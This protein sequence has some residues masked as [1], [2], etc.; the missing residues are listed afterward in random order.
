MPTSMKNGRQSDGLVGSASL[1]AGQTEWLY[2]CFTDFLVN[3]YLQCVKDKR[4]PLFIF[5]SKKG[6]WLY[7]LILLHIRKKP[8]DRRSKCEKMWI[9]GKVE[10]RSDRYFTKCTSRDESIELLRERTVFIVDD[11]VNTGGQLRDFYRTLPLKDSGS[12]IVLVAFARLEGFEPAAGLEGECVEWRWPDELEPLSPSALGML[13]M[14]ETEE[15]HKAGVPFVIDLPFLKQKD[16]SREQI[17]GFFSCRLEREQFCALTSKGGSLWEFVDGSYTIGMEN[18]RLGFFYC[19][20]DPFVD[21][22]RCL[23]QN[24]VMECRYVYGEGEDRSVYVTLTPFAVMRSIQRDELLDR[25]RVTFA[26]T[27]YA[28]EVLDYG[29]K[30]PSAK[31]MNLS[32]ALYRSLVFFFSRYI[33]INFSAYMSEVCNVGL[34]LDGDLI[35]DHWPSSFLNSLP[36]IF[37]SNF[38]DR[39]N[40]LYGNNDATPYSPPPAWGPVRRSDSMYFNIFSYFAY[41]RMASAEKKFFTIEEIESNLAASEGCCADDPDF[42]N[43]FTQALLYLLN[44]SVISNQIGYDE[45]NGVVLRGFRPAE[46]STFLLP[47]DQKAVFQAIYTYYKR[48][49][50][51]EDAAGRGGPAHGFYYRNYAS[52]KTQ[53]LSYIS[54]AGL[55]D[56]VDIAEAEDTL[57]YFAGIEDAV[58]AQQIENKQYIILE[59]ERGSS[60]DARAARLLEDFVKRMEF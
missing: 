31:D 12:K 53:L 19:R 22:F 18:A 30:C 48:C 2:N 58:L 59:L 45:A 34:E 14:W 25:F 49:E 33:S 8:A 40:F 43:R 7:R 32:T 9:A 3:L 39:L 10:V 28:R 21:K 6:Y 15:F 54:R 52:F 11:F 60:K 5:V 41:Q 36:Q 27:E 13:V 46:N 16:T 56:Y 17:P 35:R 4:P 50:R 26:K 47:F 55:G 57:D 51:A 38:Q 37:G 24:L 20:H 1:P 42:R 44:Q 29:K 23:I